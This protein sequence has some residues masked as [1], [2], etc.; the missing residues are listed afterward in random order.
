MQPEI[1]QKLHDSHQGIQRCHLRAKTSVWW[2]GI[3]KQISD[4]IERY[5]ICEG[6]AP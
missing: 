6:R 1:L 2:P 4:V 3:S 5:P